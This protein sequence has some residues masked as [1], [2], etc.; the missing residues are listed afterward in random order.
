MKK[1]VKRNL[2]KILGGVADV[3]VGSKESLE[4]F[5]GLFAGMFNIF[6]GLFVLRLTPS[7]NSRGQFVYAA[8]TD[9]AKGT[10]ADWRVKQ[11]MANDINVIKK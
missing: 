1:E 9:Y 4:K 10:C 11:I 6:I 5:I 7:I 8:V 2:F 3:D